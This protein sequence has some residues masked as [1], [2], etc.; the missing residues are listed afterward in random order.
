MTDGAARLV[1]DLAAGEMAGLAFGPPGRDLD[2][3]FLHANGFNAH[4]YRAILAPLGTRFRV[5]AVDMRGH[6]RSSLPTDPTQHSWQVYADDLLELLAIVGPPRVLAGHSMGGATALL[7]SPNL[8]PATKLVLFDPVLAPPP[9]YAH[10]AVHGVD[11]DHPMAKGALRRKADF[12]SRAAAFTAYRGRG[13]FATWRDETLADYLE[14]GLRA[15]P[16][17]GFR[18]SCAPEWEAANFAAAAI[19]NPNAGLA[20]T[21]C[22]AYVLKAE[23]GSVCALTDAPAQVRIEAIAGSSHFLP[24]EFPEL[25]RA[26]LTD[27][28]EG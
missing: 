24:M 1:F 23:I 14:D 25:V 6:G 19:A 17:G 20:E 22:P 13:A 27:A 9:A 16:E 21:V 4:T 2:I 18:L 7:A 3:L 11:Y 15:L 28:L 26:V 12:P 5:L 8:P 10:A